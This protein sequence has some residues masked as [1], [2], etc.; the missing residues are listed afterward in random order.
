MP[1]GHVHAA[2]GC[3]I[4]EPARMRREGQ[5]GWE[6]CIRSL[7]EEKRKR[8]GQ[9]GQGKPADR[10]PEGCAR[11]PALPIADQEGSPANW[12]VNGRW[13]GVGWGG[14]EGT[15]GASPYRLALVAACYW[16]RADA[17]GGALQCTSYPEIFQFRFAA[18]F[19][20]PS[21]A[22]RGW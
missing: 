4:A 14:Q 20:A 19:S 6:R 12:T 21:I 22:A 13:V 7:R 18:L 1:S 9:P 11:E 15:P 8:P 17:R 2:A 5:R 10:R 3:A 16:K